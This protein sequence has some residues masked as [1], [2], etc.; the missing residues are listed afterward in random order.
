MPCTNIVEELLGAEA[1]GEV[2]ER[3]G[4]VAQEEQR[5]FVGK[6]RTGKD[7]EELLRT[8]AAAEVDR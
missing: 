4:I 1:I 2:V 7:S 3:I 5:S 8:G 6:G